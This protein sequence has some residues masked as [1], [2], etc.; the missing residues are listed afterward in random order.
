MDALGLRPVKVNTRGTGSEQSPPRMLL[1]LLIYSYATGIFGRRRIEQSTC[2][3]V[4][5]RLLAADTHPDHDTLC[6][7]RRQNQDLLT[8]TFVKVLQL[9]QHLKVLRLGQLTVAADGTKV[10]ASA[11]KHS[12]V[13]HGR[14]G[15]MITPLELEVRH[16]RILTQPPRQGGAAAPPKLL[17]EQAQ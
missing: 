17:P 2:D 3:S 12:A 8:E 16:G 1:A 7:F 6:T 14:A 13:S 4:P 15:E 5:V 10:L 9:A 11:S